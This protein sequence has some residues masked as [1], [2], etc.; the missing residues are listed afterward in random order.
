VRLVIEHH[1]GQAGLAQARDIFGPVPAR[2]LNEHAA[3]AAV[4]RDAAGLLPQAAPL[5]A[6]HADVELALFQLAARAFVHQTGAEK[7]WMRKK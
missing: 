3:R 2:R 6:E 1:D 4:E 7:H 5:E